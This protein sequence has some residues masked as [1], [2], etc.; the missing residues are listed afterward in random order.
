MDNEVTG[1]IL[2]SEGTQGNRGKIAVNLE[3]TDIEEGLEE[4]D[5]EELIGKQIHMN[6]KVSSL[7]DLPE[8]L[9]TDPYVTYQLGW[10]ASQKEYRIDDAN[11][12]YCKKHT[13]D[14][15][16]DYHISKLDKGSIAFHV[17]AY[18]YFK[19]S[20]GAKGQKEVFKVSEVAPKFVA[21]QTPRDVSVA[22]S[23]N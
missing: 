7:V 6:V 16:T 13:I 4:A 20:K 10:E 2:S 11:S 19:G 12:G 1:K 14:C 17:F 18:P 23:R 9:C 15:V 5:P 21:A 8:E 3:P 22:E